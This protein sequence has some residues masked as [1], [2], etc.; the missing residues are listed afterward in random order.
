MYFYLATIVIGVVVAYLI[1][2]QKSPKPPRIKLGPRP[3][4]Y[5]KQSKEVGTEK[6]PGEGLPRR[7]S[8]VPDGELVSSLRGGKITTL[9]E[10]FQFGRNNFGNYPCLGTRAV[11]ADGSRG[12]YRWKTYMEV[13]NKRTHLGSGL[14]RL[15]LKPHDTV[16]IYSKNR[17]GIY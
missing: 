16:G 6:K 3:A 5:A 9:Y 10:A 11:A 17:E 15:G 14:T 13:A 1:I 2:L 12:H 4:K 8:G 7:G